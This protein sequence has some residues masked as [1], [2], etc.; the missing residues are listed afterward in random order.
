VSHTIALSL[1]S[2]KTDGCWVS[3]A[4][5]FSDIFFDIALKCAGHL[6]KLL[7]HA[8]VPVV[9]DG[10]VGTTLKHFGDL[11]PFVPVIAMHQVEDPFLL[12]A[13]SDLLYFRVEMIVPAFTALF[14]NPTWQVFCNQSPFLWAIFVN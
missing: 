5:L 12:P 10:I 1:L 6:R 3:Y 8:G 4:E 13:P 11:S 2:I 9:L 14:P 7:L